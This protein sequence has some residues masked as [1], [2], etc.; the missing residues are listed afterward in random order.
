[1][2]RIERLVLATHNAG[3]VREFKDLIA[4][5]GIEVVSADALGLNEPEE[6][7]AT[8]AGNAR[9]KAHVLAAED[10]EGGPD[11]GPRIRRL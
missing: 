9:L 1:M 11:G 5:Y 10:D 8:F 3:K 4:P 7:E 2:R 6:T